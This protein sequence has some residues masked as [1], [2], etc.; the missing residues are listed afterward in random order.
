MR[1]PRRTPTTAPRHRRTRCGAAARTPDRRPKR[2]PA[3]EESVDAEFTDAP[4]RAGGWSLRPRTVRAKIVCLLMVPVVSLL[5][6]WAYATVTTA[7]DISRL[8]QLQRVDSQV[9]A[10]VAAAVAAL[11]EERAAAVGYATEPAADRA[12]DLKKLAARTDRG[13]GET[14]ARGRQHRR[15]QR[16]T[17]LRSGRAPRNLRHRSRTAALPADRRTRPEYRLARDVRAVHQDHRDGLLGG[18]RD[19]PASRTRRSAPTRACCSNSRERVRPSRRRTPYS[20]APGSPGPS[21]GSGSG[22]SPAPSTRAGCSPS[23]P[24]PIFEAPNESP[25]NHLVQGSAYADVHAVENGRAR[26]RSGR[27][28]RS[29]PRPRR[30]GTRRTRACRTTCERSKRTPA[31]VSRTG[32]TRSPGGLLD[33]GR[34]RGPAGTRR[35]GRVARHLRTHRTWPRHRAGGP[36]QHRIWR[37]P[38]A[39]SRTPCGNCVRVRRSTSSRGPAQGPS[40]RR[41]RRDR[42]RKP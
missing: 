2:A 41:T 13:R 33:T 11:Q 1:T 6:L 35:R 7:Q 29:T 28:G 10:P 3:T 42:S 26:D 27:A 20:R 15:R 40:L 34:C 32:P 18:R 17:A 30:P 22:C 24:S 36:A 25:G 38:G 12:S 21:T 23:R 31:A 39:N 5:A 37:S 19:S 4:T 14:P 8:R 16:G 9:R